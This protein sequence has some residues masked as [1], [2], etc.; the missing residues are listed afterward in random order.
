[1]RL[2]CFKA[3]VKY[4]VVVAKWII[5]TILSINDPYML[6]LF[7]GGSKSR[8]ERTR[9]RVLCR[10]LPRQS[11]QTRR[12]GWNLRYSH[13]WR[14]REQNGRRSRCTLHSQFSPSY[15][16]VREVTGFYYSRC[17]VFVQDVSVSVQI[18][19]SVQPLTFCLCACMHFVS[20]TESEL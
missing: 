4:H 7:P 16:D 19:A 14:H 20:E 9:L 5:L 13:V 10:G 2:L 8:E 12:Q 17:V 11:A 15:S 1:M 18:N 3:S 6:S